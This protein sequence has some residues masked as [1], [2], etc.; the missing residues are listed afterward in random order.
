MKKKEVKSDPIRDYII[1]S[2][3]YI[4]ENKDKFFTGLSIIVLLIATLLYF[5][6][7]SSDI[8]IKSN[9]MSSTAQ[10]FYIDGN[11][12]QSINKFEELIYDNSY[13]NESRNQAFVYLLNNAI[14]K[15]DNDKLSELITEYKFK[16]N[17]NLL[18]SLYHNI[19]GD[20]YYNNQNSEEAIKHYSKS[21]KYFDQYY[22]ILIDAK[23]SIV[24]C[25]YDK[26]DLNLAK[27]HLNDFDYSKLSIQSK[28]KYDQFIHQYSDL[29]N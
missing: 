20:Y 24:K 2:Y 22:D 19:C 14:Q 4:D 28:N 27:K 17:D 12:D 25:Y 9:I 6:N 16:T 8:N 13:S 1:N 23:L 21:I 10:N 7:K 15:N 11:V 5:N 3:N 26:N 29:I 18:Y